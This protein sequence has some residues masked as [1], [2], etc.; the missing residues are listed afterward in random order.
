MSFFNELAHRGSA[1]DPA[2]GLSPPPNLRLS[3]L[4][5]ILATQCRPLVNSSETKPTSNRR[6]VPSSAAL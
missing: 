3:T 1:L 6:A 4:N 2:E 5:K